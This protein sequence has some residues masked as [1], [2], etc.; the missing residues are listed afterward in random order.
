MDSR[1]WLFGLVC[2]L[3]GCAQTA[4]DRVR[5]YNEDG[6]MLFKKGDYAHA[7]ETFQAAL[8][9][10][11]TD[12]NLLFN[13]GQCYDRLQQPD[14]AEKAYLECIRSEPNHA[15]CRHELAALLWK[16]D[17]KAESAKMVESWLAKEPKLASA[18]A[19]HGWLFV[20]QGDLGKA[21]SRLFDAL[22]L[23]GSDWRALVA[24]AQVFEAENRLDRALVL[25]QRALEINPDQ[26]EVAHRVASLKSQGIGPP[27]PD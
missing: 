5:E 12:S 7:R 1:A 14:Q 6:V 16:Q 20:Q 19:L 18:F 8:A 26:A 21:K 10:K 9:L 23:D 11:P 3:V 17:R 15:E 2:V 4:Q 27:R 13:I 25:Y 24:L 22:A